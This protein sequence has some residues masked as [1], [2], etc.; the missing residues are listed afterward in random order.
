MPCLVTVS[1]YYDRRQ[2]GYVS[3]CVHLVVG[4]SVSRITQ[5]LLS[6]FPLN[7]DGGGKKGLVFWIKGRIPKMFNTGL[8]SVI[9]NST[10]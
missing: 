6:G 1:C 5:K 7:F 2:G 10:L 4:G 9:L 8:L 3:A